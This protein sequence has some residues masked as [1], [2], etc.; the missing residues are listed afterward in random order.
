M[1]NTYEWVTNSELPLPPPAPY[2]GSGL[3]V[4]I[5]TFEGR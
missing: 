1:E 3:N 2:R 4:F 5:E